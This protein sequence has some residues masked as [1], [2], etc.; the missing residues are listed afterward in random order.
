MLSFGSQSDPPENVCFAFFDLF[1]MQPDIADLMKRERL[2][3]FHTLLPHEPFAASPPQRTQEVQIVP[4]RL[5]DIREDDQKRW[6][7]RT[8]TRLS[9]VF[10]LLNSPKSQKWGCFRSAPH[11]LLATISISTPLILPCPL[12][13]VSFHGL[14]MSSPRHCSSRTYDH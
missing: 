6:G 14:H 13:F 4:F 10:F 1:F 3:N 9:E 12:L 8:G 7:P 5:F 2:R 11:Y